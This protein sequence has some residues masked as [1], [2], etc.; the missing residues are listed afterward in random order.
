[1]SAFLW[2]AIIPAIVILCA[3]LV[4]K[5]FLLLAIPALYALQI[6]RIALRKGGSAYAWKYAALMM[7]A[8]LGEAK[9]VLKYFLTS[10]GD[11]SFDYKSSQTIGRSP[12]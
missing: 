12:A 5:P 1:M 7:F 2:A 6:A 4:G 8:K 3:F 9:G 11:L 10:K